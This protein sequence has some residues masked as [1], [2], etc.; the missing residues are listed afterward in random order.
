LWIIF[1]EELKVLAEYETLSCFKIEPP[2]QET[3]TTSFRFSLQLRTDEGFGIRGEA[4]MQQ[5]KTTHPV[6][7]RASRPAQP[8]SQPLLEE[9]DALY[10]QRP[11]SSAHRYKPNNTTTTEDLQQPPMQPQQSKNTWRVLERKALTLALIVLVLFLLVDWIG[12]P[13][14]QQ[15]NT[16][17]TYGQDLTYQ[18]DADLGHGGMSHLIAYTSGGKLE[19]VEVIGQKSKLYELPV[20]TTQ[21]RL[22]VVHIEDLNDDGKPDLVLDVDGMKGHPTL[23]NTGDGFHWSIA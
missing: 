11:P 14:Y 19:V 16:Q 3:H 17:Y 23:I 20:T 15:L 4:T 10:P 5:S 1:R 12:Y 9:D 22:V 8:P 13:I 21:K 7:Q 2:K 6:I 18:V